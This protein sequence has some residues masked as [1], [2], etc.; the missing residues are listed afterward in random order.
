MADGISTAG[1]TVEAIVQAPRVE[2]PGDGGGGG[3]GCGVGCTIGIVFA[4]LAVLTLSALL[5]LW[6]TGAACFKKAGATQPN[7]KGVPN[8]Q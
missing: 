1:L 3:G 5:F 2:L 4:V 6:L 7:N 8:G